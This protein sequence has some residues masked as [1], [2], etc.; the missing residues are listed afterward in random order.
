VATLSLG[1]LA[2]SLVELASKSTPAPKT[3]TSTVAT[4][5]HDV[6]VAQVALSIEQT[7]LTKRHL[8]SKVSCPSVVPLEKG[9]TFTCTATTEGGHTT[10]FRVTEQNDFGA[11]TFVGE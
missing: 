4:S 10:P 6:N 7:L 9:R 8:H 2:A 11:V 3:V 5:T 1:V